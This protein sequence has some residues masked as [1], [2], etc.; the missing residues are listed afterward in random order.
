MTGSPHVLF[1]VGSEGGRLRCFQA[2]LAK[3]RIKA[4]FPI[5]YC[6]FCNKETIYKR[7]EVCGEK[8]V[9]LYYCSKCNKV[10]KEKCHTNLKYKTKVIDIKHYFKSALDLL[11]ITHYPELIK[12]VRGTSNKDH[13]PEHLAKGILRAIHGIYVNKDGTSRYDMTEMPITHFK[14]KE[15]GTSIEKLKELGYTKDIFGKD[16]ENEEQILE[17]KPQDIILPSSD[18]SLDEKA[19]DFLY[20]VCNFIDDL[21]VRLYKMDRFYNLKSKK[22]IIGHLV[23]GLSPHTSAGIV[24][25]VIG[26]SKT[27]GFL[28]HPYVHAIM[29]RDCDGDE[30]GILLLMDALINFSLRYLPAHR[31]VKQDEPLI[32]TSILIPREVDDMVFDM[33]ISWKYPLDFYKACLE[34]KQPWDVKCIEK[35]SDRLGKENQYYGFGF[36]HDVDDINEGVRCSAYKSIP[37]MEEKVKG[38]MRL[39]EKIR[40]VDENDVARLIIE[41]H[42]IRDIKGNLRKFSMQQF[43]CVNCNEKYRRPP[44]LGVCLKC[45]GR[46]IFTVAEGF[47][48]KYLEPSISLVNKYDLPTYLKQTLILT[49]KRIE[50]VFGKDKEKQEGLGKWF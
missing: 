15:I 24:L 28:A 43:R 33:D 40:A 39:A 8:T 13:I 2:A 34:F 29:R 30:A 18:D 11:E 31:G 5:F 42:F 46:I 44:L 9:Q 45:G 36:T 12:G 20:N 1:P 27:Q 6:E 25:R 23:I 22:D 17:I 32:L 41:R 3:G 19:D 38:Q 16:L 47:V 14:P 7:C 4:Q 50:S 37:S 49:K 26:F 35:V 48:V 10:S 21:L